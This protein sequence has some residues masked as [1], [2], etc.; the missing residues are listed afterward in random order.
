MT[1]R[2][3]SVTTFEQ[4]RD[5][6]ATTLGI[7]DRA[8]RLTPDTALWD[9]LPEFDSMAVLELIAALEDRFDI[10]LDD[11]EISGEI[12]GTLGTLTAFVQEKLDGR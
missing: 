4:V 1:E 12:F 2:T 10:V 6:L 8:D 3:V 9:A 7:K 5:V 11:S